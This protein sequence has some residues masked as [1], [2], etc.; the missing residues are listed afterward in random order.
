MT[1]D[2]S[3]AA[4]HHLTRK[5]SRELAASHI[6]VTNLAPGWVPTKMGSQL[7]TYTTKDAMISLI[8]LGRAGGAPDMVGAVL[9]LSSKASSWVTGITIPVD[10][11]ALQYRPTVLPSSL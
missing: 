8:P 2:V 4:L 7:L 3:K 1:D 10:G 6:T 5:L 11:G 9:Y